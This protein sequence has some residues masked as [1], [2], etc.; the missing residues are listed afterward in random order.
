MFGEIAA[1]NNSRKKHSKETSKI[2]GEKN[3]VVLS[4]N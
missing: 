1:S 3:K 2:S 4:K